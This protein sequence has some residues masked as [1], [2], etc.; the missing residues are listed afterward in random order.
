MKLWTLKNLLYMNN[1][2]QHA[3]DKE[4]IE[5]GRITL[6]PVQRPKPNNPKP[7]GNEE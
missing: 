2:Q 7:K 3:P 1:Q 4:R 5:E 6:S